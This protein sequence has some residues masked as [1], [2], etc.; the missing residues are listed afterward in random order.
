MENKTT[1]EPGYASNSNPLQA[2]RLI[3]IFLLI[4]V[5]GMFVVGK[6]KS[7][8]PIVSWALYSGYSARFRPPEPSVSAIELRVYTTTGDLHVVKPEQV[9]TLPRDSLAHDIVEQA[10]DNED[11]SLRDASR[12]YLMRAISNLLNT[13]SDIKTIQAW[14]LSYQVEPLEVPP[15][16]LQA[17][18]S[19]VMLDSFSREDIAEKN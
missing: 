17:P 14:K 18:T 16:Q 1:S 7:T 11:V 10:F 5:L 3:K 12:R 8:W 19:E 15:I 13:N 4:V 2:L 6:R 9:L